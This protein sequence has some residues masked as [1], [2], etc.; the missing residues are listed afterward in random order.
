MCYYFSMKW[1]GLVALLMLP[2]LTS[3][4]PFV[5]C[6]YERMCNLC[7]AVTMI[8]YIVNWLFGFLAILAVIGLM[9]S[10]FRLVVSGGDVGA[11]TQAKQMF[12]NIVVGFVIVLSAW[13][14]VD[15]IMKAFISDRAQFGMWNSLEGVDCGGTNTPTPRDTQMYC[16]DE[17]GGDEQAGTFTSLE[18]CQTYRQRSIDEGRNVTQCSVCSF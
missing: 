9:I 14:I 5:Q 11:W 12:T 2:S 3:A 16:F 15:T 8:N 13:L 6:G 18:Q 1:S 4:Q 10:G 17:I 7:D